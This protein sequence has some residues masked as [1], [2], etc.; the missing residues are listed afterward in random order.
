MREFRWRPVKDIA[1]LERGMIIRHVPTTLG[2]HWIVTGNYDSH[3]TAVDT[4][5]V[6]NPEEW[7]VLTDVTEEKDR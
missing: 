1:S 5:D 2:S 3:V 6:T 4:V 7:E